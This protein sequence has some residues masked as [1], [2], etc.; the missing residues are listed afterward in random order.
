MQPLPDIDED[1][2]LE[3][4]RWYRAVGVDEAIAETP[5]DWSAYNGIEAEPVPRRLAPVSTPHKPAD[6]PQPATRAVA[7]APAIA[8]SMAARDLA[9]TAADLAAL[10]ATLAAFDGCA[11]KKTAKSLCF[12]RGNPQARKI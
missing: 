1:I 11:L 9:R 12:A 4:L 6:L 2:A 5:Q 10:E 7:A 8:S 3:L